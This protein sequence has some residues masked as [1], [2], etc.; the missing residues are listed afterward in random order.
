LGIE[1]QGNG[2]ALSKKAHESSEVISAKKNLLFEKSQK[3]EG[4]KGTTQQKKTGIGE[5]TL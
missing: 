1:G 3:G 5:K 2:G 4:D